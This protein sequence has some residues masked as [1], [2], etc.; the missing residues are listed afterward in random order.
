MIFDA[1]NKPIP[2]DLPEPLPLPSSSDL[3]VMGRHGIKLTDWWNMTASDR[4]A[5]RVS[6]AHAEPRTA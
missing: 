1:R 5:A 6:V 4:V 3:V 2:L